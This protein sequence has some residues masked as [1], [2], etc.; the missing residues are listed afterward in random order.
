[1]R[2]IK[3][4]IY[5]VAVIVVILLGT[6]IF[7]TLHKKAEHSTHME[8]VKY[9]C[10]MH[11]TYISDKPGDC[12]ICNMKLVPIEESE[13]HAGHE[14][15][16]KDRSVVTM[17]EEQEQM[18]GVRLVTVKR[19]DLALTIRAAGRIAHDPELYSTIVEYKRAVSTYEEAKLKNVSDEVIKQTE[20]LVDSTKLKLLHM[21]LSESQIQEMVKGEDQI[22]L[23]MVGN[24]GGTVWVYAQIYEQE[25]GLVKEGQKIDVSSISL[26]GRKFTGV[27]KSIDTYLDSETRT[28]KVRA[29][30][31]NPEGLLKPEMYVD[32]VIYVNLGNK[33]AVPIDAVIDTGTRKIVF[34]KVDKGRYIPKELVTG[35]EANGFY[36]IVS[37]VEE[38]EQVVS[39]ANFLID[40]ESKLKSAIAGT[41]E[42]KH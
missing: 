41:D 30:V 32:A 19:Q 33:L 24:P 29:E 25:I 20:D 21:G 31:N 1:M 3:W 5:P 13:K 42:H 40:S 39:S 10:P 9:H 7:V 34:V 4:Y 35:Y 23:L 36:E 27:I 15:A 2:N 17:S 14:S 18:I 6:G 26:P 16:L 8:K 37:G 28:L 38:G 22:N 12:P 11:P